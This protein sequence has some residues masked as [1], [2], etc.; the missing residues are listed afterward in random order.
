[1]SVHLEKPVGVVGLGIIGQ[2]WAAA[3][4]HAGLTVRVYDPDAGQWDRFQDMAPALLADLDALH[5][6][7]IRLGDI[8]FSSDMGEALAETGFIQENGPERLELKQSLLAAIERHVAA[9][10][11]IASSSSALSVSAMQ[12]R[13]AHPERIVLGHPFNPA[14]LMPLVEIV[15]GERTRPETVTAARAFYEAIG[16]KP[17]VLNREITGHL[18]LRLMGAMWREAIALAG[19]GVASVEDIDR[20]FMYGPGPKWTLQGSFISNH[21]N[22]EGI[23]A[24]FR[25]YGGTYQDI[26][27]D[28]GTATLDDETTATVAASMRGALAGRGNDDLRA[29]RDKGLIEILATLH[30]HG[31]L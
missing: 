22:A 5:G 20:A 24:F 7:A 23:E 31:A 17:V 6:P 18:A 12:A 4:R 21:L 2:R 10:T 8:S 27:D 14:H 13:C 1:M 29:E 3:F 15:G 16:K 25:K 11:I 30:R 19:A 9:D 28:L 26:W